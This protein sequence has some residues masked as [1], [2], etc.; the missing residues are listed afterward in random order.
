VWRACA[1]WRRRVEAGADP[2]HRS[3]P[4]D[5]GAG[6]CEGNELA[7]VEKTCLP[8][9]ARPTVPTMTASAAATQPTTPKLADLRDRVEEL[10]EQ[11]LDETPDHPEPADLEYDTASLLALLDLP[12]FAEVAGLVPSV[13]QRR[14]DPRAAALLETVAALAREPLAGQARAA[15][16]RLQASGVKSPLAGRVARVELSDARIIEDQ[17]ADRLLVVLRRPREREAQIAILVVEREETGGA[18]IEAL[19]TP[20]A[21]RREVRSVLRE[22]L[23]GVQDRTLAGEELGPRLQAAA[24]RAAELEL[25][26]PHDVGVALPLIGRAL[27]LEAGVFPRLVLEPPRGPLNIDPEDDEAFENLSEALLEQFDEEVLS[28][29]GEDDPV[30][31]GGDYVA[32]SMLHFKHGYGDSRLGHWTRADL[33]EYLLDHYPRKLSADDDLVA[34]VPDCVGAFIRFLDE[35]ELLTGDTPAELESACREL[36]PR[37]ERAARDRRGW[38]PAKAITTEMLAE[39]VDLG[40]ERAVSAWM[41]E[42]NA[43]PRAERD[44]VLPG[45]AGARPPAGAG[46]RDGR[47][48]RS[49]RKATRAAR[50]RNRR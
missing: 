25:V 30:F 1:W 36:R 33:E 42:F 12:P 29:H 28:S 9:G 47:E 26:L 41:D 38:G 13:A 49:K 8:T 46:R 5:G 24:A 17:A 40:D 48:R 21:P 39:G 10:I 18:L 20:P 50:K 27:G 15:L 19:V 14:G 31:R 16:D 23:A 37:F 32:G 3:P 35:R 2:P 7:G 45:I 43:R 34:C 11:F 44:Q 6:N 4:E 22:A